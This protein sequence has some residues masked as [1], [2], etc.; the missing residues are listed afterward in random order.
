MDSWLFLLAVPF[1]AILTEGLYRK[2]IARMQNRVGPP[3]A[4]PLYDL[5]KL[6]GKKPL[7]KENDPFFKAAPVLYFL[8]HFALFLFV[9]LSIVSF[10][11]DFILLIYLTILGSA[12]FILAGVSS[13][14]PY[15]VIASM[16]EMILM[17]VYE[18]TLAII[19]VTV[20]MASGALSLAGLDVSFGFA[21][22]PLAALCLLAVG[23]VEIHVTPFD[24]A[25][26]KAEI[27]SG[28]EVEYPGKKMFFMKS[29]SYLKKLFYSLLWPTLFVGTG[30]W[31]LFGLGAFGTF[32]VFTFSQATTPRYRVDQAFDRLLIVMVIALFEFIR[33]SWGFVWVL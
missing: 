12:F 32:F 9:P 5:L 6:W 27:L 19:L 3:I 23:M 31:L 20:F 16:R 30:N 33:V 8:S 24:T 21:T 11:Y 26:A 17:V 7:R 2:L 1:L 14:S 18:I 13:D 10:S 25:S 28:V 4:Q 29:T 22:L 15:S